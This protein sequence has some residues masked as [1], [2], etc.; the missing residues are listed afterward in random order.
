MLEKKPF[1]SYRLDDEKVEDKRR[2]FSVSVNKQEEINLEIL[3][4]VSG[5]KEDGTTLKLWAFLGYKCVTST[6]SK[7]FLED[8]FKKGKAKPSKIKLDKI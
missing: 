4:Q 2:T 7:E 3:K 8:L 1:Q 6:F 5:Y